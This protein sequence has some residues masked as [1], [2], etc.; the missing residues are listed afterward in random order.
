VLPRGALRDLVN[1]LGGLE[2]SPPQRMHYRDASQKLSIDLEAGLQQLG[3]AKVEKLV[4]FR[5]PSYGEAG[6]RNSMQLV[7]SGLRE[8]MQQPERL[9]TLPFLVSQLQSKVETNLS[10]NE[11]LSLL[12]AGLDGTRP[13]QFSSLPLKPAEEKHKGLRQLDPAAVPPL[14]KA[15]S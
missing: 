15:P 3:G 11:T 1:G 14:W 8:R 7:E 9:A 4:R 12:A 6:R 10:S 13:L 2:I 5:D